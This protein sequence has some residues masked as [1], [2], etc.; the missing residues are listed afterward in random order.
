[1]SNKE[2]KPA[3]ILMYTGERNNCGHVPYG[4]LFLDHEDKKRKLEG[5]RAH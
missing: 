1:M 4:I 2:Q 3:Q 5:I